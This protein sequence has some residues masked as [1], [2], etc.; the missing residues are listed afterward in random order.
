MHPVNHDMFK[1][2]LNQ[3]HIRRVAEGEVEDK[4]RV[5]MGEYLAD[6]SSLCCYSQRHASFS[7]CTCLKDL[8]DGSDEN[9]RVMADIVTA[10]YQ[11]PY[12]GRILL[13][14]NKVFAIMDT[15]VL[16]KLKT[17]SS[18]KFRGKIFPIRGKFDSSVISNIDVTTYHVCLNAFLS[19]YGI[20]YY[21]FNTI[22]S[23]YELSCFN[24][25]R[26]M[27]HGN[28]GKR[29]NNAVKE[30]VEVA[31]HS[32]FKDLANEG[33][34]YASQQVRTNLGTTYLRD[35][36]LDDVRLPPFY[37]KKMV[38]DRWCYNQ[39]WIAGRGQDTYKG[40]KSYKK[41]CYNDADWPEGSD[42]ES[43]CSRAK[44]L[45]FWS[46]NYKHIKIA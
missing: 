40:Y 8:I 33:D 44:F 37:S 25:E 7:K 39:G 31:L 17:I 45:T 46:S 35:K 10:Y 3:S 4:F 18:M 26:N 36:E 28:S 9:I 34:D 21:F 41:I 43:I 2:V 29:S 30:E 22:K 24:T 13:L 19:T 14:S 15:K 12:K 5:Q 16:S 6:L 20:G 27:A 23:K 32:Y 11:L 38:Y 42:S 1:K